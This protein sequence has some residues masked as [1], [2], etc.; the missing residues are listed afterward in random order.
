MFRRLPVV[1]LVCSVASAATG[2]P[3]GDDFARCLARSATDQDRIGLVRWVFASTS[4]HPAVS[5][6]ASITNDQRDAI[7]ADTKRLS[8]RLITK[9]CRSE[10]IKAIR[11]EG[12]VG[13]AGG[14]HF[15]GAG[16]MQA[17]M[18]HEAVSRHIA[19]NMDASGDPE[20]DAFL[21]ET[22]SP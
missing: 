10:A 2:G 18:S 19:K 4:L 14:F 22:R 7:A 16:A 11:Y 15:L 6:L 3:F 21:K 12:I 5:S 9:D 8:I 13:I 1:A 20:F 17:L